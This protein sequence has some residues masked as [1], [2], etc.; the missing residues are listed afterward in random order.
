MKLPSFQFYPG[1]WRKDPGVQSLEYHD[2]GVWFEIMCI[3]HDS[4]ERGRLVLNGKPMPQSALA[5]LLG[6]DNQILTTTLTTLL[7]RGVASRDS[8]S[9]VIY[10]RRMVRDEKLR[11]V[12]QEAGKLGGNPVLVKQK[13]TTPVKQKPTPSSSSSASASALAEQTESAREEA[14]PPPGPSTEANRPSWEEVK[15]FADR[16]GLAEWKARDW[17]DEMLAVGWK[18]WNQRPVLNWQPMLTRVARQWEAAGRP[19]SP[20]AGKSQANGHANHRDERRAREYQQEIKAK[21]L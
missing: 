21:L 19:T 3:M 18:D 6:L 5:R 7:D 15:V 20:P 14:N 2:R 1:D 11:Q 16:I 12:R 9:G 17:L 8:E 13:P 4:E 10:C